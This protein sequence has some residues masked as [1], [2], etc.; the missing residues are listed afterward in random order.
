[1]R[2]SLQD[3]PKLR[4]MRNPVLAVGLLVLASGFAAGCASRAASS[5]PIGD[6]WTASLRADAA[7]PRLAGAVSVNEEDGGSAASISV[8]GAPAAALLPWH[9]HAGQCGSGGPI[10]G[11]ASAYPLLRTGSDGRAAASVSVPADLAVDREYYLD[12]HAGSSEL[13]TIVACGQLAV[14]RG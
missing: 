8:T 13:G 3:H 1:M 14:S 4:N 6:R 12:V 7:Y 2:A 11:N 9:I 10:V 5:S